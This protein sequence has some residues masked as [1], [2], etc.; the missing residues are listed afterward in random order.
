MGTEQPSYEGIHR[1]PPE[2]FYMTDSGAAIACTCAFT[3]YE[4]CA[5]ECGCS[6]CARNWHDYLHYSGEEYEA[7]A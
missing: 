6:A 1:Y 2:G 3:C 5:G 7:A 4:E